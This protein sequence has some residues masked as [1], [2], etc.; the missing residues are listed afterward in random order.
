MYMLLAGCSIDER[1]QA[2]YQCTFWVERND[3]RLG[4]NA[5]SE[6]IGAGKNLFQEDTARATH[7]FV[8]PVY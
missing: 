6:W 4:T 7:S 1:L 3:E 5:L 2:W 8:S